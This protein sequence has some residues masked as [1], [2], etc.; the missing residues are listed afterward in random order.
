MLKLPLF[1]QHPGTQS[2]L[3]C[4]SGPM[5]PQ[6]VLV[7]CSTFK[8]LLI[9]LVLLLGPGSVLSKGTDVALG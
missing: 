1:L 9:E 4:P 7:A 3:R 2:I 5:I 6:E 8:H